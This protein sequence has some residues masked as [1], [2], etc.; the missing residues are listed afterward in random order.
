L[1]ASSACTPARSAAEMATVAELSFMV[2]V[3]KL[4]VLEM[5]DED[6]RDGA[7]CATQKI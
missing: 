6:S 7:R 5:D 4:E 3:M 2:R 1:A